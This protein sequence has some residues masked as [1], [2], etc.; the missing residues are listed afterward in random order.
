M[1]TP[2]NVDAPPDVRRSHD[3]DPGPSR[4]HA[5]RRVDLP[6]V[7]GWLPAATVAAL[8]ILASLS[9]LRNGFAFD[10]VPIILQNARVHSLHEWWRM[11]ALSYW[12]PSFGS[13]VYRPVAILAFALEWGVGGGAPWVMH[14]ASV[15]LYVTA[16]VAFYW[17]ATHFVSRAGA[18]PAAALFAVHPVH[19]EA[20]GNL[21]GQSELIV[22]ATTCLAVTLY[23]RWRRGRAQAST[24]VPA[25]CVLYALGCCTKENGI[26]LPALLLAVEL[27][28]VRGTE[29]LRRRARSF[30]VL[31]AP[32][33]AIAGAYLVVRLGVTGRLGSN[34]PSVVLAGLSPA[35]RALTMLGVVPELLRLLVWPARLSA[36]YSPPDVAVLRGWDLAMLPGAVLVAGAATLAVACR[37]RS[38]VATA[39]L[40]WFGIALLPVS[41]LL[42]PSGVILAERTLFLPSVGVLLAAAAAAAGIAERWPVIP[43]AARRAAVAGLAAVLVAATA[44]SATRQSAWRDNETLFSRSVEDAPLSY[45]A[46]HMYGRLLFQAGRPG[47][48]ERELRRALLLYDADHKV[49]YALASAYFDA[50][51]YHLATPLFRRALALRPGDGE[52]RVSLAASLLGEGKLDEA[53]GEAR[54]GLAGGDSRAI[55]ERLIR[56]ADSVSAARAGAR[57]VANA[58]PSR[59]G[60]SG[61]LHEAV[62]NT[63]PARPAA[64]SPEARKALSGNRL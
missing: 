48:G 19:V 4:L 31:F 49:H 13:D 1:T 28:V 7:P 8:A 24:A 29:P 50:R 41:N 39:G 23:V 25:I 43:V 61:T 32:M 51:A 36:F 53:R 37:S 46:H 62:Q 20:V 42:F 34:D 26:L 18:W 11:F 57:P 17:M 55:L 30:S 60:D 33:T 35:D 63:T 2:L 52:Y 9:G 22:A 14:L 59:R 47:A 15:V 38:P 64:R 16:C 12:P 54:A 6:T 21:V 10:D 44:R 3:G 40:L 5:P 45:E 56:I 27:T 58:G